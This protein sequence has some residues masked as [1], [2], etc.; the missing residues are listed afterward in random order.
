MCVCVCM[1]ALA[2]KR[3]E[4][5]LAGRQAGGCNPCMSVCLS[6]KG[7]VDGRGGGASLQCTNRMP[8]PS[9]SSPSSPLP[10]QFFFSPWFAS[11]LPPPSTPLTLFFDSS[12]FFFFFF[13]SLYL[14]RE[15]FT[16][17]SDL[18]QK[19]FFVHFIGNQIRN[20]FILR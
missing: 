7:W 16:F 17:D 8:S 18:Y 14:S 4:G 2:W 19:R 11:P 1:C 15:K 6:A 3:S 10:L 5:V 13:S 20:I 9:P 12:F